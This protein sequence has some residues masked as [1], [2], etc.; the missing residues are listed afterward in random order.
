MPVWASVL[1]G[2]HHLETRLR[3]TVEGLP[4][5]PQEK[6]RGAVETARC[7]REARRAGR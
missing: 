1:T 6:G 2:E 7:A 5:V 3:A 4:D